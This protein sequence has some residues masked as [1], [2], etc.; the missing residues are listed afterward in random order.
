MISVR[1]SKLDS[2]VWHALEFADTQRYRDAWPHKE[3][4]RRC[5][6]H[7][8][9]PLCGVFKCRRVSWTHGAMSIIPTTASTMNV[10]V[11]DISA[12]IE[13]DRN[14]KSPQKQVQ[15]LQRRTDRPVPVQSPGVLAP[16]YS[17]EERIKAPTPLSI[18]QTNPHRP[19]SRP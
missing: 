5:T 8:C 9:C 2:I 3:L 4:T 13:V 19:R 11:V 16:K 18:K 1:T 14:V 7:M 15:R 10:Y 6:M 12:K 17:E